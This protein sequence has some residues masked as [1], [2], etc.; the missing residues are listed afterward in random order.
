MRLSLVCSL[1]TVSA[2]ILGARQAHFPSF[3]VSQNS[4]VLGALWELSPIVALGDLADV[5]EFGV[6]VVDHLPAPIPE[7]LHTL[8]WCQATFRPV[9]V[10]KGRL[11]ETTRYVWGA[12]EPGCRLFYGNREAYEKRVTRMWFLREEQGLLRPLL[13]AGSAHF[14]GMFAKWTDGPDLPPR[15]RLGVLLLTPEAVASTRTEFAETMWDD[16]DVACSLLG[17]MECVRRIKALTTLGEPAL[18]RAAC[19]YLRFQQGENCETEQRE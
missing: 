19:E 5:S 1:G 7:N 13:D 12:I 17:K 9:A 6:Q 15:Q 18:S 14:Y 8:H 2:L 16:A 10:V 4:M 11:P 3:K